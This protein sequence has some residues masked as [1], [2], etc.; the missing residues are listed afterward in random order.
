MTLFNEKKS[1]EEEIRHQIKNQSLIAYNLAISL[2]LQN[3]NKNR[4]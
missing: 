2:A 1:Q 3:K 4:E